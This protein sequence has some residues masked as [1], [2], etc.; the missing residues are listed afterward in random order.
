MWRLKA[1]AGAVDPFIC[2]NSYRYRIKFQSHSFTIK[3]RIMNDGAIW[4]R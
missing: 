1:V 2:S 3:R 4:I